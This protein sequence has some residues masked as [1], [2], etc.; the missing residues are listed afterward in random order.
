MTEV[1]ERRGAFQRPAMGR[2]RRFAAVQIHPPAG[3]KTSVFSERGD[4][5][6]KALPSVSPR[7]LFCQRLLARGLLRGGGMTPEHLGF[8]VIQMRDDAPVMRERCGGRADRLYVA[9]SHRSGQVALLSRHHCA[10]AQWQRVRE[11]GFASIIAATADPVR[12]RSSCQRPSFPA[13]PHQSVSDQPVYRRVDRRHR[14]APVRRDHARH[15]A[16]AD[17]RVRCA[18]REQGQRRGPWIGHPP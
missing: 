8:A 10:I 13:Q 3:L 16:R 18:A 2:A 11:R 15:L 4:L 17:R 7:R 1:G 9:I 12:P 5:E 14:A 6:I